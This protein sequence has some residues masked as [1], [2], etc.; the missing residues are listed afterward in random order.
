MNTI[1][2]SGSLVVF[3]T[4]VGIYYMYQDKRREQIQ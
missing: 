3:V 2:I 4:I 1:I